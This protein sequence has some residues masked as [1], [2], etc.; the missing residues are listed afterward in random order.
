MAHG[1]VDAAAHVVSER[2]GLFQAVSPYQSTSANRER[3]NDQQRYDECNA[4]PLARAVKERG[5]L[6]RGARRAHS[7]GHIGYRR[8]ER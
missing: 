7:G 1:G 6:H 3:N 4:I 8:W 5:A 2:R